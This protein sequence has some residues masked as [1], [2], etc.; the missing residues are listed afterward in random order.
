MP[1]TLYPKAACVV[2][3]SLSLHRSICLG[4]APAYQVLKPTF[5]STILGCLYLRVKSSNSSKARPSTSI[6]RSEKKNYPVTLSQSFLFSN[7]VTDFKFRILLNRSSGPHQ[8]AFSKFC[9][10]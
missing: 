6:S 4:S 2:A 3:A 7:I 1:Q 9:F 8:L 10:F 5:M